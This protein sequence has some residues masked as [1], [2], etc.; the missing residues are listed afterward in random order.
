MV[1][2]AIAFPVYA[3]NVFH[4]ELILHLLPYVVEDVFAFLV[5]LVVE[6]SF[7]ADV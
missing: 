3:V 2:L 1:N 5:R 7:K 4:I 6:A